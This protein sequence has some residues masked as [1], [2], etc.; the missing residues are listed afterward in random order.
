MDIRNDPSANKTYEVQHGTRKHDVTTR[1]SCKIKPRM[2]C[3]TSAVE[4][5]TELMSAMGYFTNIEQDAFR[6]DRGEW[7]GVASFSMSML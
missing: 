2:Y 1:L 4:H 6:S 7:K 5:L 3:E